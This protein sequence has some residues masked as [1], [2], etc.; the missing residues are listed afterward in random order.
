MLVNNNADGYCNKEETRVDGPWTFGIQP[1]KLNKKGDLARRNADII[2]M[3]AEKALEA[4]LS[5]PDPKVLGREEPVFYQLRCSF[6]E[7]CLKEMYL[8]QGL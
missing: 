2:T 8:V 6:L 7:I 3:G 4:G 5:S 1:A